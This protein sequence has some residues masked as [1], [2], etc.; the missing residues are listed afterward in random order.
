MGR[1][2]AIL[3]LPGLLNEPAAASSAAAGERLEKVNQLAHDRGLVLEVVRVEPLEDVHRPALEVPRLHR[4]H[5]DFSHDSLREVAYEGLLEPR[6]RL[7]HAAVADA[8]ERH[9]ARD[10][11]LH[12]AALAEHCRR[13]HRWDRAVHHLRATASQAAD[14]GAY[15][16]AVALLEDALRLLDRLAPNHAVLEQ[17]I[18]LRIDLR[19]ALWPLGEHRRML[20]PLVESGAREAVE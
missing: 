6:R 11:E 20:G 3:D 4:G 8:I 5:L 18:D 14:R 16:D 1:A 12:R 15:R 13:A 19:N 7:L 9:H 10:L 2:P 17:A